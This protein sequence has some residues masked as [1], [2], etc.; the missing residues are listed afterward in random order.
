MENIVEIS[1][2]AHFEEFHLFPQCFP[3][4]FLAKKIMSWTNDYSIR[5]WHHKNKSCN[6]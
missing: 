5:D 4:L 2:I 6:N 3:K 1:A